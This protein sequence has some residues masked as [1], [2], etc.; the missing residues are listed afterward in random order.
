LQKVK[1]EQT[2]VFKIFT[3]C[4]GISV[5]CMLPNE[6]VNCPAQVEVDR[7]GEAVVE[8]EE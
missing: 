6:T 1:L 4:H 7:I 3:S 5:L 2:K 8:A